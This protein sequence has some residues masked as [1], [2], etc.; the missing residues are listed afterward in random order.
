MGGYFSF[1]GKMLAAKAAL[2]VASGVVRGV[3]EA[4]RAKDERERV[5]REATRIRRD[6][7]ALGISAP[8]P[9][10]PTRPQPP[11]PA[12][13]A[14]APVPPARAAFGPPPRGGALPVPVPSG[15]VVRPEGSILVALFVG[16]LAAAA[17]GLLSDGG[18]ARLVA[19]LLGTAFYCRARSWT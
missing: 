1:T 5:A 2:D 18:T 10:Q 13:A 9:R 16:G 4:S 12:R 19:G 15:P 11:P 14:A 6:V 3:S 8:P 17:M 7:A